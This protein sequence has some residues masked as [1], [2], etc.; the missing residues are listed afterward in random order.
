MSGCTD[1]YIRSQRFDRGRAHF[2]CGEY[3]KRPTGWRAPELYLKG[4]YMTKADLVGVPCDRT[5]TTAMITVMD[6][7][8]LDGMGCSK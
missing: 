8:G 6:E 1:H 2:W 5:V 7:E 3:Q 4:N